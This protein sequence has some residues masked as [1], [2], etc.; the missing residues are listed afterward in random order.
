MSTTHVGSAGPTARA[1]LVTTLRGAAP[2]LDSFIRYHLAR[3]FAHLYLF[4]DDP[5]DPA[6]ALARRHEGCGVTNL[7]RGDRPRRGVARECVQFACLR[8]PPQRAK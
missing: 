8:A 4:F 7:A 1:A 6:L 3:G 5:D 2:V